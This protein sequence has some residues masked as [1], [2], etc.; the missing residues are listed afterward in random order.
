MGV[1]YEAFDEERRASVALKMLK[2]FD[3]AALARFKREFRA[4]QGLVHPN[5]V[6]LDELFVENEQ[7]FFTMELLAGVEFVS[8]VRGHASRAAYESTVRG[9]L[10]KLA[11]GAPVEGGPDA[12]LGAFDERKLRDGLRQLLEGLAALH[13]ADKVHRDVKPSNVLV[14]PEGRVVLLDFG[15]VT[16]AQVEDGF[17]G[18]AVVGTPAYMAPEQAA[19]REVGPAA[20]LYA[21][22]VMLY[23][24][25]TG[26]LPFEGGQLQVLMDKQSK[27]PAPPA[28]LVLGAPP[29]LNALCVRL[30]R[31][32]PLQRPAAAEALRAL[33]ALP[34]RASSPDLRPTSTDG[35]IFVGRAAELTQLREAYQVC[36]AGQ[37]STVLVCGE[38]G[39]GKSHLVR[40]FTA[41]ILADHPEAMVLEG[42]CYER[43][44]V[45]YKTLDGVVDSLG[46]RLA[47]LPAEQVAMVLPVRCA[48]LGQVFPALLRVPQIAKEHAASRL[49]VDP[50]E[51]RQRAFAALRELLARIAMRRPAIIVIDDLQWADDD[52]LRALAEILREP[53]APPVLLIGTVRSTPGATGDALARLRE[54]IPGEAR[55]LAVGSLGHDEARELARAVLRRADNRDAD[56][57]MIATEAAGHPLFV[58][59]LARHVAPPGAAAPREVKL[60]DAIWTRVAMLDPKEREMAELVAVAGKPI[61]QQVVAAAAH[62][63]PGEFARRA[64]VLRAAYVVRTGGARWADAIEPYHDRVREAVLAQ[65]EPQRRRALHEA[66]AVAFEASS[67]HDAEALATHWREAGN[68]VRAASYA[69][70]AGDHAAKAFAFDR[71]AQWYEE[72]LA[73]LPAGDP[74]VRELHVKLGDALGS[75]GRGALAAPHFEQAAA[76]APPTEALDLKRKAAEHLLRSGH[77]E[78][79]MAAM[80]AVLASI[81]MHLPTTALGKVLMLLYFRAYLALRGFGFREREKS[82][83]SAGDLARIDTC[84]GVAMVVGS[85]DHFVGFVFATRALLLALKA[86]EIERIARS[87]GNEAAA[88]GVQG[89]EAGWRRAQKLLAIGRPLAERS[90]SATARAYVLM[91]SGM[92]LYGVGRFHDMTE[93]LER[94][95]VIMKSGAP[96]LVFETSAARVIQLTALG[97]LGRFRELARVREEV[98]RD[99]VA[100]GDVF[101]SVS[102]RIGAAAF[103]WAA[104]DRPELVE[105]ETLVALA[106]WGRRGFDLEHWYG[107]FG[108]TAA[109][110]YR[111]RGDEAHALAAQLLGQTRRSLMW[112]IH[113][114]RVPT[115]FAYCTA[116]LAKIE[117]GSG[118]REAL[119]AEARRATVAL[120]RKLRPWFRGFALA[121]RAG[122]ARH[123]SV[124]DAVSGLEQAA[125]SF[126]EHQML[127]FAAAARYHAAN[128]RGD[129]AERERALD[130]LRSEGVVAPQR[131]ARMLIGGFPD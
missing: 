58:E 61:P 19:S 45:P 80:R 23:E 55:V 124:E 99:A 5:L 21:V 115:L 131:M 16:D 86:G 32:D 15:L 117:W 121:V 46:S 39:I 66:L 40:R 68:G 103:A 26:R 118:D 56:P 71:A 97:W 25:L 28:S 111:G 42:R 91:G 92:A 62:V 105:S 1:V 90:G 130:Y 104:M 79:G 127:G 31:F 22:G 18:S 76:G 84:F 63:E 2:G 38:S 65:L 54:R 8:H 89:G 14:T 51:H 122:I 87:I 35:P 29:D 10:G 94:F 60:D 13:A 24:A 88:S 43:E 3:G 125:R 96:G 6:A 41:Q 129:A 102:M 123:R 48:V 49:A 108:R 73:L 67:Q 4:L 114:L 30:L 120:E 81:G 36:Q 53:E 47:R 113:D 119:L 109:M 27:E 112:G 69:V 33:S 82:Q 20:D 110:G 101:T 9:S 95:L 70:T 85:A 11:A 98:Y 78:R 74:A 17:T 34:P 106:E 100:R 93:E 77:F 83:L 72:A 57:E 116:C 75:A 44:T 7:W 12:G 128:L 107:L 50:H 126:G 59:E 64:A 37:L 52:G